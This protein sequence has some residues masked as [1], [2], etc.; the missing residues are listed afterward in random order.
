M[1]IRLFAFIAL[2]ASATLAAAPE[3]LAL[4]RALDL[5]RADLREV[6]AALA[7]NDLPG[8]RSAL[9]AHFRSRKTPVPPPL[10]PDGSAGGIRAADAIC[11]HVFQLVTCPPTRL[12]REIRWN[13]DPHH[14]DQWAI[15]LNR[16]SHWLPLAR[17]YLATRDEKYAREFV[18]QLNSWISAMPVRIGRNYLEGPYFEKGRSLLSLDAGIRMAQTWWPAYEAF[19]D[20][21]SFDIDSQCR[22]LVSFCDHARYLADPR[23]FHPSSNWGA[24]EVAGLMSLAVMLP[25]FKEAPNWL[26]IASARC[27]EAQ[28]AQVYPDGAQMELSPGYHWVTVD[29]FLRIVDITERNGVP[30][31][32][33]FAKGLESMFDVLVAIALPN[34]SAPAVNDSAWIPVGRPLQAAVRLFPSRSDFEYFAS[35]QKRGSPPLRKS[36]A[37]PSAGWFAM[38][39]G[40]TPADACLFFEAGP[41]GAAHQHEDKL[42]LIVH[43]GGRTILTEGGVYSYDGSDWQRYTMSSRAH[44]TVLVDGFE[45]NRV[46]VRESWIC[47]EPP[48]A[49]WQ[50]DSAFDFAEGSYDSGY[51]PANELRVVHTRQVAFVKPDY[52]LVVDTLTPADEREHTYEALFHLDASSTEIDADTRAVSVD[53]NARGFRVLPLP[54]FSGGVT[55]VQGRKTPTLQGWLPSGHHN[56]L[57]PIPTAVYTWKG[58]GRVTTGFLL[59]PR[60]PDG[61]WPIASA[62]PSQ[63]PEGAATQIAL[64]N[65]GTDRLNLAPDMGVSIVRHG[66]TGIAGASLTVP[67]H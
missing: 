24:M 11:Q 34:G 5:Q 48:A 47:R 66:G 45:Q 40:W 21:P 59:Q 46:K 64:H 42:S 67:S 1:T 10:T 58:K 55:I 25:E 3:E 31:P 14:Y 20:S 56:E 28:Q 19:K 30:L 53:C 39:T 27:V 44:N 32:A 2:V 15:A 12:G 37:L 65:G 36:W 54:S 60:R 8:A 43:A 62:Q 16:H 13:E 63:S 35:G 57:R 26:R 4:F 49:R 41:F 61:S 52:W 6:S 9:I 50:S 7:R 18:D 22:L 33:A 23:T 29:N 51:G 17:A 38:R